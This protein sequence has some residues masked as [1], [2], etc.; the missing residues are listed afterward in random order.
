LFLAQG[1]PSAY[2]TLYWNLEENSGISKNN[3]TSV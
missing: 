1:L 2:H 3:G